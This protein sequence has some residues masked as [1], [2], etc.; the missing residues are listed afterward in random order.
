MS[1]TEDAVAEI[2]TLP[3]F[4]PETVPLGSLSRFRIVRFPGDRLRS[5]FRIDDRF[6]LQ[7]LSDHHRARLSTDFIETAVG[8]T[9]PLTSSFLQETKNSE[10][11]NTRMT[12][13]ILLIINSN[14]SFE[15]YLIL[16]KNSLTR[17]E[18][19]AKPMFS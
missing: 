4:T 13:N 15:F 3:S 18:G 7:G 2:F 10:L 11:N 8:L 5:V 17:F 19:M 6:K 16:S 14:L 12:A 1:D 9:L